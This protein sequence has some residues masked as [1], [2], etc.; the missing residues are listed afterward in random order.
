MLKTAGFGP[1]CSEVA[2][3][4]V[5]NPLGADLPSNLHRQCTPALLK[6]GANLNPARSSN[7]P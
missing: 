6:R 2:D 1:Q 4:V 7:H 5:I 3:P